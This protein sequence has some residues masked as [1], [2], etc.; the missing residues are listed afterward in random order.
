NWSAF[1]IGN[2]PKNLHRTSLAYTQFVGTYGGTPYGDFDASAN[3]FKFAESTENTGR[4]IGLTNGKIGPFK[5]FTIRGYDTYSRFS[6][7]TLPGRYFRGG[8]IDAYAF[9]HGIR[10]TYLRGQDRANF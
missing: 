9:S 7:L 5:D 4:A 1:Y 10:Y 6:D 2:N 8:L 3:F